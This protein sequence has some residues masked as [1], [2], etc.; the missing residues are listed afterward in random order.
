MGG[1][2]LRQVNAASHEGAG[3]CQPHLDLQPS[4]SGQNKTC[5]IYN[6]VCNPTKFTYFILLHV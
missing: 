5:Q 4:V 2:A 1:N 6:S 3:A